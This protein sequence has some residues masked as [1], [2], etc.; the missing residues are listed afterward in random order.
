MLL[1]LS[2]DWIYVLRSATMNNVNRFPNEHAFSTYLVKQLKNAGQF[3]Q[4]IESGLTG[5]GIP[6]IFA[7]IDGQPMWIELKRE[8]YKIGECNKISWRPGQ[9]AWLRRAGISMMCYTIVMF[10]DIIGII[11]HGYYPRKPLDYPGNKVHRHQIFESSSMTQIMHYLTSG[12]V[13][14]G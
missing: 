5:K 8:H 14:G 2:V 12:L 7:I 4:R 3:V 11:T 13:I 10:D 1:C 9:R 6:D